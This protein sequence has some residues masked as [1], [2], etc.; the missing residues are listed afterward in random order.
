MKINFKKTITIIVLSTA[1]GL[2]YNSFN[3]SGLKLISKNKELNW[4]ADSVMTSLNKLNDLDK[5]RQIVTPDSGNKI[6][7]GKNI[8]RKKGNNNKIDPSVNQSKNEDLGFGEPLLINLNQAY[9]LFQMDILF[10]D[11]RDIIEYKEGHIK[12]ALSLPYLEFD[13]YKSVQAKI[14]KSQTIICY[15]GG[16]DCELSKSLANR[17]FSQGYHNIYVFSGGW[18]QWKKAGYPVD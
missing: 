4:A 10:L 9:K 16:S 5:V 3:P 18:N 15:C 2:I 14:P 13:N 11:A 17:L 1:L 6:K 7:P 12:K 8:I